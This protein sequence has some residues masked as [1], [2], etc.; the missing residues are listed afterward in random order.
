M[1]N[2]VLPAAIFIS[3]M[4]VGT[5][6]EHFAVQGSVKVGAL[7]VVAAVAHVAVNRFQRSRRQDP[8]G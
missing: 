2:L 5:V 8:R 1:N 6:L 4:A 7:C 3:V